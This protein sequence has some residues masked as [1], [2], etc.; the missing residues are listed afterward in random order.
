MGIILIHGLG[1]SASAWDKTVRA[2]PENI[3]AA[4]PELAACGSYERLYS[5]FREYCDKSGSELDLC[6]LSLGAVLA[7]NYSADFPERVRSLVLIAGQYKMPRALM[8]LQGVIFRLMP[9]SAFSDTGFSKE[10]FIGLNHSMAGLDLTEGL[11]D[12]RAKTLVMVGERDRPNA[13]AARELAALLHSPLEIIDGAGHEVNIDAPE[14]L[15]A[16]LVK[17]YGASG[18]L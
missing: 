1:Q 2:L 3:R 5:T 13:K 9:R 11:R 16:A 18:V 6:G 4:C 10:N 14:E 15:A 12:V 8:R 17:F 7:L